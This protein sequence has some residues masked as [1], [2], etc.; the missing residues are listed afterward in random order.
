MSGA[1]IGVVGRAVFD[2]R[3]CTRK[4]VAM[5]REAAGD[6]IE[7]RRSCEVVHAALDIMVAAR[8]QMAGPQH[9]RLR[10]EARR[11]TCCGIGHQQTGDVMDASLPTGIETGA[12]R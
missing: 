5:A 8:V 9:P 12:R 11:A 1:R 3:Q 4:S 6:S 2:H 10:A 7:M